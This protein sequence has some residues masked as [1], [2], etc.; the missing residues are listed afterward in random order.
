MEVY[1]EIWK[2]IIGVMY[3][4]PN[5]NCHDFLEKLQSFLTL[6]SQEKKECIITL[7]KDNPNSHDFLNTFLYYYY[8]PLICKPT[9][10]TMTMPQQLTIFFLYN[11][12]N[13]Y[14]PN[15]RY[16]ISRTMIKYK[17]A[18]IWNGVPNELHHITSLSILK[19]NFKSYFIH[20]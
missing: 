19:R 4:P 1:T 7:D 10:I 16:N 13:S 2:C 15:Y 12:N 5:K 17:G 9:R 6:I 8:V 11:S 20:S 14:V 18:V 3:R